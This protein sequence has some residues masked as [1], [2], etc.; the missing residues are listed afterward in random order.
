M[1]HNYTY[2]ILVLFRTLY[3]QYWLYI[4][5]FSHSFSFLA[6]PVLVKRVWQCSWYEII[7]CVP[8]H[9]IVSKQY[10]F[11]QSTMTQT[12]LLL[13]NLFS[14]SIWHCSLDHGDQPWCGKP[15][16]ETKN[17]NNIIFL[18][19]RA[20]RITYI[21][22]SKFMGSNV[23]INL[24][25]QTTFSGSNKQGYTSTAWVFHV[26]WLIGQWTGTLQLIW[27]PSKT[28]MLQPVKHLTNQPKDMED[29]EQLT[30]T[31]VCMYL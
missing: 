26:P 31:L 15:S 13:L 12:H 27:L 1:V 18:F 10:M 5:V 6:N 16:L 30:W 19:G 8:F 4:P 3:V 25:P 22:W 11:C 29:S 24:N 23:D 28:G 20:I 14:W 7:I 21:E 2:V 9:Y 17:K